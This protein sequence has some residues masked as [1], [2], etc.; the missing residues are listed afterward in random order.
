MTKKIDINTVSRKALDNLLPIGAKSEIKKRLDKKGI[1]VSLPTM[2]RAFD[3][4]YPL[5]PK[6]ERVIEEAIRYRE[7]CIQRSRISVMP[8]IAEE[9]SA[10]GS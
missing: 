1:K 6:I 7:E 9:L 4:D 10:T 5:T 8:Q 3:P 2:T